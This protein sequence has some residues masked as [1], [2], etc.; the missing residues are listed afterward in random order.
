MLEAGA[1]EGMIITYVNDKP[2]SKPQDVI[3][4]AKTSTRSVYIEGVSANGRKVFFG[5]G[6]D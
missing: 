1:A 6:K 4:I 3:D 2:V 5:F